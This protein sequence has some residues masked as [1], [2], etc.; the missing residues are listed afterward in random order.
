MNLKDSSKYIAGHAKIFMTALIL[1]IA[2]IFLQAC[3]V[4]MVMFW[5]MPSR[6]EPV[7]PEKIS[8]EEEHLKKIQN[9]AKNFLPDG[10][11]HLVY[12]FSDVPVVS[13]DERKEE[14]YDANG[15]LL[16]SGLKKDRPYEYL[17]WTSVASGHERFDERRMEQIQMI[18]P[19][20]SRSLQIPVR[21]NKKIKEI[22]RYD[23]AGRLFV[24]YRAEGGKV[25]YIGSTGYTDSIS[26]SVPFGTFKMF[27]AWCP[28][29]SFNPKLLWQTGR[30]VYEINF[31][32][33]HVQLIFESLESNIK[34]IALH[35]WRDVRPETPQDSN[36][37]YLP[38]IQCL[39]EDNK[40]HLII[41]NPDRKLTVTVDDDWWADTISFTATTHEIFMLRR[42]TERRLPLPLRRSLKLAVEWLRKFEGRP[43]K[44]WIELYRVDNKG[45]L[46]LLNRYDWTDTIR[47]DRS[48]QESQPWEKTK[49]YV[50][51]FSSPLYDLAWYLL[52]GE[53]WKYKDQSNV[54]YGFA[55]LVE[56]LRPGNSIFNWILGLAMTAFAFWHGW[57]RQTSRA[58]LFFWLL[59][60]LTFNL[61]G[62]LTYLALNHTPVIKCSSCGKRRGL[63]QVDCLRCGIE[64]PEPERRK[65]DLILST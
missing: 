29:N 53:F 12:Q 42:D 5:K 63:D 20:F 54:F 1:L 3:I 26:K 11:I 23:P 14:V 65:L 36:I 50:C 17:S 8:A 19:E 22:W 13:D 35:R 34:K 37:P 52:G 57:P 45:N 27:T 21:S 59:F 41:R 56:E 9:S 30:R 47:I 31:E 4:Q 16:W 2:V 64:L 43:H 38:L 46:N 58:K 49:R 39:T 6:A 62:L 7:E 10:T 44:E 32:K 28:R 33:L 15:N 60:T 51:Q 24:G 18:A 25:G 48:L 61:A 40:H 55:S